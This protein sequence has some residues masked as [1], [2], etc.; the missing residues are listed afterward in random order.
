ME[1]RDINL[2]FLWEE[3]GG[4]ILDAPDPFWEKWREDK[5]KFY[6]FM[7][8]EPIHKIVELMVIAYKD[9]FP[10]D[11]W[12]SN[13]LNEKIR[14]TDVE[15]D[16]N[17]FKIYGK[18]YMLR[19]DVISFADKE[20]IT[21]G[22]FEYSSEIKIEFI[23]GR[24]LTVPIEKVLEG[25]DFSKSTLGDT[26]VYTVEES[27]ISQLEVTPRSFKIIVNEDYYVYLGY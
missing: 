4:P 23:E 10:R 18:D 2:G 27:P 5:V 1:I 8:T 21:D 16:E 24:D 22:E 7:K 13:F 25:K 14:Q 17:G 19:H 15:E 6:S 20:K 9:K 11:Y 26:V 3:R 12:S